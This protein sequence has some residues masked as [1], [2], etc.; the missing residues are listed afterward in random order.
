MHMSILKMHMSINDSYHKG[1]PASEVLCL[2]E[3]HSEMSLL[4]ALLDK[5][6]AATVPPD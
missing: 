3:V 5:T 2:Q 6:G 1:M 4:G